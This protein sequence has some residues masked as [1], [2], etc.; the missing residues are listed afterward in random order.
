MTVLVTLWV[1]IT[2]A[3]LV[4]FKIRVSGRPDGWRCEVR[5]GKFAL[6]DTAVR[7]GK[8]QRTVQRKSGAR[9]K[10]KFPSGPFIEMV[11]GLIHGASSGL[12]FLLKHTRLDRCRISGTLEGSDPAETGILFGLLC[13]LGDLL[14]TQISKL[15][16]AIVPEFMDGGTRLWFE[17]EASTRTGTL[18]AFPFVVLLHVPKKALAH[19][20][21]ESLRR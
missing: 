14:E 13:A 1:L 5:Y 7:K 18:L 8:I 15:Q 20:A 19:F 3:L 4:R 10:R 11:P 9:R 6:V 21:I 2:V 16:V 12:R 17:G